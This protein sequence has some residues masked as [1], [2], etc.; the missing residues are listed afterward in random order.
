M[1]SCPTCRTPYPANFAVCPQDGTALVDATVWAEGSV[2]RGKYRILTKIGQGG[3]GAVYKAMHLAFDE[4]RALKVMN[5]GLTSDELFVKRFKNEA[6]IS[7]RLQHPNAV[8]VDDIDESEDGLPF[9]VMEFIEGRSLKQVIQDE[10]ALP[11]GRVCAL[12]KQ[13]AAALEAA[14]QLGMIHRDIKPENIVL[15]QSAA[16]EQVKI[17]DFGIAK[18]KEARLGEGGGLTLTGTGVVVGTPQYM[19]PEQA[20]GKRGEQLDGR[21]DLYSLGVVMYQMLTGEL[22]FKAETTMAMLLAHLQ[23][24]PTP[25]RDL[26]PELQIPDAVA[27][28]VMRLLAKN[29]DSRPASARVLIEELNLAE[30]APA[31]LE[32]TR[33]ASPVR[34]YAYSPEESARALREALGKG[35]PAKG[36]QAPTRATPPPSMQQRE[37]PPRVAPPPVAPAPPRPVAKP[38]PV[39]PPQFAAARPA[40]P[41]RT[42]LWIGLSVL[43]VAL[44]AGGAYFALR[45]SQAP[46]QQAPPVQQQ[47]APPASTQAPSGQTGTPAATTPATGT[48]PAEQTSAP[49]GGEPAPAGETTTETQPPSRPTRVSKAE[50]ARQERNLRIEERASKRAE[51]VLPAAPPPVDQK[52]VK[53]ALAMGDIYFDRGQYNDA[54]REYQKGL[55]ADPAN[56]DLRSRLQRAQK[57]KA[58]E[59]RIL[60]Q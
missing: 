53:A 14:H 11:V 32:A 2:I 9:I 18:V 13:A 26:K 31:P 45:Q 35:A 57:A 43:A 42:G 25:I 47:T 34:S 54:I 56:S 46:T 39:P 29:P 5:P 38:A 4:M 8:R 21:S 6:K 33:V 27:N 52:A 10:G 44:I 48:P 7:R 60:Q 15:V 20:M 17:L 58:A 37:A 49:V 22:P 30:K 24:A 41:S 36:S 3:M 19:S 16:G 12:I 40:P 51:Q 59:E 28:I 1:K 50:K 23:Q 55:N